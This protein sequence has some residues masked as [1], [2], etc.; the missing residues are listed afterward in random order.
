MSVA[1]S[2]NLDRSALSRDI[3]IATEYLHSSKLAAY[4]GCFNAFS[5]STFASIC[6]VEF[7]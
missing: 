3:P 4:L 7:K 5:N 6:V 2:V 1:E